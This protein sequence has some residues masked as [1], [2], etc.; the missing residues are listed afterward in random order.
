MEQNVG[1]DLKLIISTRSNTCDYGGFLLFL[2]W[3]T[4]KWTTHWVN[5]P[6]LR[7]YPRSPTDRGITYVNGLTGMCKHNNI[8]YVARWS[9]ILVYEM[10]NDFPPKL[11]LQHIINHPMFND[12]HDVRIYDGKLYVS[13]SG[14]ERI[15]CLDLDGEFIDEWV[16]AQPEEFTPEPLDTTIRLDQVTSTQWHA[17]HANASAVCNGNDYVYATLQKIGEVRCMDRDCNVT[18]VITGLSRP[19]DGHFINDTE[20]V[21]TN[22]TTFEIECYEKKSDT[23]FEKKY[24]MRVPGSGKARDKETGKYKEVG[25]VRGLLHLGDYRFLVG[26]SAWKHWNRRDQRA[27]IYEVD[28]A[29]NKILGKFKLPRFPFTPDKKAL[30]PFQRIATVMQAL[31]MSFYPNINIYQI[32]KF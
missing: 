23:K 4:G 11:K 1:K 9:D 18:T 15:I 2:D 20:F 16:F 30:M 7:E 10:S 29:E 3:S 17:V 25:W 26:Q 13:S 8:L 31:K 6:V 28:L 5:G 14:A 21:I 22:A 24:S 32:V 12:L 19:H 27:I